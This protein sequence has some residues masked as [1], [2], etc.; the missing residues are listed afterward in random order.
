[1]IH[2]HGPSAISTAL[3]KIALVGN[4]NVGKSIVFR[5]LTGRYAVVSNYP[6]TT[7]ELTIG[8]SAIHGTQ[9]E[10]IDTPGA[11]SLMPSS[12]DERV[13]RDIL[14][15]SKGLTVLQVADA[16]NLDRALMLTCQLGELG[17]PQSSP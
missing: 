14:L 5:M 11:N 9:Y 12:E 16:K 13:A 17:L 2:R 6:G 1:M 10:V 3:P 8:N 15:D 7:V 4:P